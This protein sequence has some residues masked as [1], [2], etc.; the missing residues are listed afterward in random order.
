M[1]TSTAVPVAHVAPIWST[2]ERLLFIE[3]GG[4][5]DIRAVDVTSGVTVVLRRGSAYGSLAAGADGSFG[6]VGQVGFSDRD[7]V[8]IAD[9][10]GRA[11]SKTRIP[12]DASVN[13]N[14]DLHVG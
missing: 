14:D 1:T 3:W 6:Y 7:E 12:I 13:L 9:S 5:S 4:G 8:V 10:R 11:L 2:P